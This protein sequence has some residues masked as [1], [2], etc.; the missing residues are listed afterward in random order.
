MSQ[1]DLQHQQAKAVEFYAAALNGWQTTRFELDK[2]LLTLSAAGIGLVITLI[3]TVGV[4]S[5]E[6][7]ILS[8]L[9]MICFVITLVTV[10]TIF[11]RNAKYLI[12]C[13]SDA[14]PISDPIL[15]TLDRIA[16]VSFMGGV[17]LA[18]VIGISTAANAYIDKAAKMTENSKTNSLTL[19]Q[20]SMDMF[21]QFKPVVAQ[22]KTTPATQE[23]PSA[24]TTQQ[25]QAG[26]TQ[27]TS[28]K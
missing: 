9:T 18:S 27:Q 24:N 11:D 6:S 5:I 10:L 19:S 20:E 13:I 12:S 15:A 25:T 26:S 1:D 28:N 23:T 16:V 3:S 4:R 21:A 17:I 14:G 7:L 2:S 22:A 8:L